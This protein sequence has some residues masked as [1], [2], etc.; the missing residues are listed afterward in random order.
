MRVLTTVSPGPSAAVV[1]SLRFASDQATSE[2]PI[3]RFETKSHISSS[4]ISHHILFISI[5]ISIFRFHLCLCFCQAAALTAPNVHRVMQSV[6]RGMALSWISET[7]RIWVGSVLVCS[8][9]VLCSVMCGR[10]AHEDH[11]D[12]EGENM[13]KYVKISGSVVLCPWKSW[14]VYIHS[15]WL[16]NLSTFQRRFAALSLTVEYVEWNSCFVAVVHANCFTARHTIQSVAGYQ[17]RPATFS[18]PL[19]PSTWT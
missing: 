10:E 11:E 16:S 9:S 8:S 12:H 6:G 14:L 4:F 7:P 17:H 1:F 18:F 3:H 15:Q 19:S 13:W 5:S 2:T